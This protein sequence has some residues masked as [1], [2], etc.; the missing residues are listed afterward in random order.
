MPN[1]HSS[2]SPRPSLDLPI[3][4][5]ISF[6]IQPPTVHGTSSTLASAPWPTKPV[7]A[8]LKPRLLLSHSPTPQHSRTMR[9]LAFRSYTASW[10]NKTPVV[11]EFPKCIRLVIEI[12]QNQ[13]AICTKFC[14]IMHGRKSLHYPHIRRPNFIAFFELVLKEYM[15]VFLSSAQ[16][17][18]H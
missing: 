7:F 17:F 4:F 14:Y 13:V 16:E 18:P 1:I 5:F 9:L 2:K 6:L 10:S 11:E 15:F 8:E 12:F 3:F